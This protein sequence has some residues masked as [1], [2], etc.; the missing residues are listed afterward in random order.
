MVGDLYF[1]MGEVTFHYRNVIRVVTGR[2]A[3]F[4]VLLGGV[5]VA[6]FTEVYFKCSNL[7]YQI[8]LVK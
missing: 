8:K 5:F 3:L 1:S 7:N 4:L 2:M 6:I